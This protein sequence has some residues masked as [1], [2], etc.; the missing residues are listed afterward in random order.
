MDFSNWPVWLT[1]ILVAF[2]GITGVA[3]LIASEKTRK[4]FVAWGFPSW[5]N[6][7]NGAIQLTAAVLLLMDGTRVLGLGLGLL[8]A[9]GVIVAMIWNREFAHLPPGVILLVVVLI[10]L[11]GL[12]A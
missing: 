9:I 11:W 2:F 5:F 1:Y 6:L 4:Q 12:A 3:N 8:V 7:A 10:D